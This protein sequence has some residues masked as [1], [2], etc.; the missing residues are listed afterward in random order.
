MGPEWLERLT[1]AATSS[2]LVATA[3]TLT[4]HGTILS[5]PDRNRPSARLPSGLTPEEASRLVAR[6]SQRLRPVIPTAVGHCVYIRRTALDLLGGF[7]PA[8]GSGYGEEVD[9][10]QRAVSIGLRHVCAD[11]VFVFHRGSGSFGVSPETRARQ[12]A[13]EAVLR[14]R[15]RWYEAAAER[16]AT[17]PYSPLAEA[18]LIARRALRGLSL[19]IDA[20]CL[21]PDFMGTQHVVVETIRALAARHDPGQLVVL[22]PRTL[23]P[24]A[25]ALERDLPHVRF[26]HVSRPEELPP[27]IALDLIYRPYQVN[28]LYELDL[29]RRLADRVVVNQL[30]MIAF[31]NP[32]YFPDDRTWLA[33]RDLTRLVMSTVDGAAFI[34]EHGRDN[35]KAAGLLDNGLPTGVVY[36]GADSEPDVTVPSAA[37]AGMEESGPF[38]LCLG[39]SYLHKNRPFA[40][41]VY[42]ELSRRGWPGR[43]VLAGPTPPDGNSLAAEA[44]ATLA[45]PGLRSRLMALGSLSGAHKRWLLDH[46]SLVLYPTMSEG[47]GLVPFEA[48]AHG[49]PTL[50]TRQGSLD[51]VLPTGIPTID[52]FDV[53]AVADQAW[54]LLTDDDH[55]KVV[56]DALRIRGRVVHLGRNRGAARGPVR[57]GPP[58]PSNE[59]DRHPGRRD[60]G[61]WVGLTGAATCQ[62]TGQKGVVR[63]ARRLRHRPSRIEGVSVS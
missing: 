31:E 10:S 42:R 55:A 48:A 59:N 23:P 51:E 39:A 58:S 54:R 27:D 7:D 62:P 30:D 63:A 8:F 53:T 14:K 32:A 4:N 29:L 1:A 61:G 34:S 12:A 60:G 20:N 57:G 26:L 11:D 5:L 43:L 44:R 38:L 2:S 6:H 16:A 18:L 3:S 49:V 46:A 37:P 17:D 52:S 9:F 25:K 50:S 13:N 45:D 35:A 21:G 19:G 40:V 15:Y 24:Y 36:C 41:E 28:S 56:V 33:Y 47:F 22:A